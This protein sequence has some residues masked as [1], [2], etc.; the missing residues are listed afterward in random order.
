MVLNICCVFCRISTWQIIKRDWLLVSEFR[1]FGFKFFAVRA[2]TN[3]FG[4]SFSDEAFERLLAP[5]TFNCLKFKFVRFIIHDCLPFLFPSLLPSILTTRM[6][7]HTRYNRFGH[8][9]GLEVVSGVC[10]NLET[11]SGSI[12]FLVSRS[13][14]ILS[15]CAVF[16]CV[17]GLRGL[18]GIT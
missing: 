10:T 9:L 3:L 4:V 17:H 12:L 13:F 2:V 16:G 15:P 5:T 1:E 7:W 18:V 14:V 11:V 6:L 8:G